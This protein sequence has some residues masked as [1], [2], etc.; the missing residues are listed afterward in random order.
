M[1]IQILPLLVALLPPPAVQ[2]PEL[3]SLVYQAPAGGYRGL[4]GNVTIY[5]RS[6]AVVI[7]ISDYRQL[8]DLPGAVRD[9]RAVAEA[10]EKHGFEVTLLVDGDA[11]RGRIAEELGDR[12]PRRVGE[13][14]RIL[15]YFAGH[16]VT[17][18]Q[19]PAEMGYLMPAEGDNQRRVATGIAMRELQAWLAGYPS[20]HVMFL[21]DACYSGL[22]LST[23]SVGLPET[24]ENYLRQVTEKEV[25]LAITAGRS[26][27]EAHEWRGQGLFTY[28]LIEGLAG[29]GDLNGDG[30][31]TSS[32]LYAYLEPNVAQTALA[33]WQAHQNPQMGRSGQGEFIFLVPGRSRDQEAAP[34]AGMPSEQ[35][36]ILFWQSIEQSTHPQ[37]FEAYLKRF[38][39][40]VF[41]ELAQLKL[42]R[43]EE[44]ARPPEVTSSPVEETTA[45]TVE[46]QPPAMEPERPP[47]AAHD[48]AAAP[49]TTTVESDREAWGRIQQITDPAAQQREI[50]A[51]LR[52]HPE[53]QLAPYAHYALALSHLR[54]DQIEAFIEQGEEALRRLPSL[55]DIPVE[56]A[57]F[58]AEQGRDEEATAR[59]QLALKNLEVSGLQQENP[60]AHRKLSAG[61]FYAMGRSFLSR[62]TRGEGDQGEKDLR[63]ALAHFQQALLWD[64][65]H[66]YANYRVGE[67]WLRLG[68]SEKAVKAFARTAAVGGL[69][70]E[71]GKQRVAQLYPQVFG[72]GEGL[73][74]LL[75]AEEQRLERELRELAG[76]PPEESRRPSLRKSGEKP[77]SLHR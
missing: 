66:P 11:S 53:S 36:D 9:A 45:R 17:V 52:A 59:A 19:G 47:P 4:S 28:F 44:M 72:S 32:E 35:A 14:D 13:R 41:A 43:L 54:A 40:G 51:F 64:P 71:Q 8:P 3:R 21:A 33:N 29:N 24:L 39:K 75:A 56:L 6:H 69:I 61:A 46:D 65:A 68:D 12:L 76:E 26:D 48:A 15:I 5:D 7:G 58:Y 55:V 27:Q 30:I 67:T 57:F 37:D 73:E 2:Q 10:L 74:A 1:V 25:R 62:S 20:K 77:P 16:G 22:A 63:A 60:A 38:P 31:V 70:G 23:R 49:P 18:G 50:Q 42:A 34:A